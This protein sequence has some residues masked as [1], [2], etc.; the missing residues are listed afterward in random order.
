[1][2][3]EAI[4]RATRD[5]DA[6]A[7]RK[8]KKLDVI[9]VFLLCQDLGRNPQ[10]K[11]D[12]DFAR[13][14]AEH[15][16]LEKDSSTGGKSTSGPTIAN[17]Y[18]EWRTKIIEE[19]GIHLDPKRLFDGSEKAAIYERNQGNCGICGRHVEHSDAE[20]DHFPTPHALGGRTAIE[21]GRLVHEKCHPRG[22]LKV[23]EGKLS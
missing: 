12:K 7:K 17:Y 9:S 3:S 4:H 5:R 15:V 1:V 14:V 22:P 20:Y 11:F 19:V 6:R 16:L 8:F 21:N 10:F 2:F 23:T 13:K 18:K